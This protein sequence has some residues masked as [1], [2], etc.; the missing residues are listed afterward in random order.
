[1]KMCGPQPYKYQHGGKLSTRWSERSLMIENH[2]IK[3]SAVGVFCYV[4]IMF[5][6]ESPTL[7]LQD[8]FVRQV[9]F[10]LW[11]IMCSCANK[12]ISFVMWFIAIHI[13]EW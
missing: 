6:P 1:L 11:A 12:H 4:S 10:M 3:I 2:L 7:T 5:P 9:G 8:V 13:T